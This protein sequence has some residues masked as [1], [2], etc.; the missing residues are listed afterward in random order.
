MSN[1]ESTTMSV[2]DAGKLIGLGRDAAYQAA[3][4]GQ[5]PVVRTGRRIR[6]LRPALETMIA[7]G[8]VRPQVTFNMDID[9][10]VR[11][12][13]IAELESRIER[14]QKELASLRNID[15]KVGGYAVGAARE[16]A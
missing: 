4:S 3:R 14:D 2:E 12:L 13:R 11:K 7:E 6:V 1:P 9:A 5:L 10:V 8:N 16:V 15:M